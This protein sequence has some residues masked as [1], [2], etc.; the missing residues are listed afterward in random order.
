M[1]DT[2]VNIYSCA[3][4]LQTL[5]LLNSS[6]VSAVSGN[7]TSDHYWLQSSK[8]YVWHFFVMQI[9]VVSKMVMIHACNWEASGFNLCPT[10]KSLSF[11]GCPSVPPHR[12]WYGTSIRTWLPRCACI[13]LQ[14]AHS[15]SVR[16]FFQFVIHK[17]I[18]KW[19]NKL[20]CL[21]YEIVI[22]L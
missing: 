16:I 8:Y 17:W 2:T 11:L 12:C 22:A 6:F 5:V 19:K 3:G 4:C 9:N 18:N 13:A 10:T 21:W 1:L 20:S 15:S 7:K 14:L